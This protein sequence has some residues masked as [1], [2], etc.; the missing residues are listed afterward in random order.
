LFSGRQG[1]EN[2]FFFK[3]LSG[4]D[5]IGGE[6]GAAIGEALKINS[7]VVVFLGEGGRRIPMLFLVFRTLLS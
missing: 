7:T 3:S 5:K 6:A 1:V 4:H 2:G